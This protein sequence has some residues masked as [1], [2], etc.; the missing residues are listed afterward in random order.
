MDSPAECKNLLDCAIYWE[1]AGADR[2][3]F[4]QPW[5]AVTQKLKPGHGRKPLAK[6]GVQKTVF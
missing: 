1:S 3:C 2:I 5:A 6:P 4:I